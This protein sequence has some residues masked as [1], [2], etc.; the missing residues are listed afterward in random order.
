MP[1]RND[2]LFERNHWLQRRCGIRQ[3]IRDRIRRRPQ[4]DR[5]LA[6]GLYSGSNRPNIAKFDDKGRWLETETAIEQSA[7][8]KEVLKVLLDGKGA[9]VSKSTE[10]KKGP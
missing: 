10:R 4:L 3:C 6:N 1:Y 9:V 2:G 8:P 5:I 7:L